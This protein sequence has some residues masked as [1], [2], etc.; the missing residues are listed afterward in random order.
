MHVSTGDCCTCV[1]SNKAINATSFTLFMLFSIEVDVTWTASDCFVDSVVCAG[2][3]GVQVYTGDI[4]TSVELVVVN[5]CTGVVIIASCCIDTT[6]LLS[7]SADSVDSDVDTRAR[8][9]MRSGDID[10][11]CER[12]SADSVSHELDCTLLRRC[13]GASVPVVCCVLKRDVI[14]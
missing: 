13:R 12:S 3:V 8:C 5:R 11:T 9:C 6:S 4:C 14:I 10:D 2:G 7:L 1:E